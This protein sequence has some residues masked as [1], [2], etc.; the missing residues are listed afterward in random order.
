MRPVC[1]RYNV[2]FSTTTTTTT[3]TKWY[4]LTRWSNTSH[5]LQMSVTCVSVPQSALAA[6][7]GKVTA[8]IPHEPGV[9]SFCPQNHTWKGK[10]ANQ[11][12]WGAQERGSFLDGLTHPLLGQA[13]HLWHWTVWYIIQG[14]HFH[15][16]G[17][18]FCICHGLGLLLVNTCSL[19]GNPH[20]TFPG[21]NSNQCSRILG[22]V[23]ATVN[24]FT[25]V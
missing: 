21:R 2:M 7:G 13:D 22:V 20:A 16:V 6:T 15:E 4:A 14:H 18:R 11:K 19:R 10:K 24:V 9:D 1:T 3:T 12:H 5:L 25:T 8:G 17:T 23:L